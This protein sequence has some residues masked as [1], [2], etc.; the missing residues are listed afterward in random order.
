MKAI[1]EADLKPTESSKNLKE[2]ILRIF[3]DAKLETTA[4][5][6]KGEASLDRFMELVK[7]QHVRAVITEEL[8]KSNHVDLHKMAAVA[9]I[10]SL[11]EEFPLG[12]IRIHPENIYKFVED[13]NT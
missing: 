3:P 7:K 6:I 11:D 13:L 10:V 2:A 9:G 1:I 4:S 8:K 12:K 5:Q